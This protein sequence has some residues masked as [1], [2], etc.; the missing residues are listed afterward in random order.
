MFISLLIYCFHNYNN[1][2]L[3]VH[4][5]KAHRFKWGYISKTVK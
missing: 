2:T 1:L 5:S 3:I 4:G